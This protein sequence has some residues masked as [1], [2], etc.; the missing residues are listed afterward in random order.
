MAE[1]SLNRRRLRRWQPKPGRSPRNRRRINPARIVGRAFLTFAAGV[2]LWTLFHAP[3]LKV[4]RVEVIG[5]GRLGGARV[6]ELAGIPLGRNIFRL[7]LYRAREAVET[8]PLVESASVTRA[9][10]NVVRV[11]V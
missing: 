2:G 3:Q 8:D 7:N 9:L 4:R 5:A 11:L 10:P 1:H 6:E